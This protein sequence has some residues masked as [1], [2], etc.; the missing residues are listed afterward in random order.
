[1]RPV[2]RRGQ[3][4]L[5]AALTLTA[6]LL[7]VIGIV[8][9]GQAMF[10]RQSLADR[11]RRAAR[12][13]AVRPYD[14][15]AIRNMVLFAQSETPRRAEPYLGLTRENVEVSR[16]DPGTPE[17]R[18]RITVRGFRLRRLTP[19]QSESPVGTFS[20]TIPTEGRAATPAS[21]SP[22]RRERR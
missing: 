19:W 9:A 11:V 16:L 13:G 17:E 4:L 22:P 2:K 10:A 1:M 8:D 21:S 15:A 18:L 6:F 20:E 12:W 3:S 7:L 5:E 14:E